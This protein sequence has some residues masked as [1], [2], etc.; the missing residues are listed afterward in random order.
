MKKMDE[1]ILITRKTFLG[2]CVSVI[3]AA[4]IPS[5]LNREIFSAFESQ[6]YL[7]AV[8]Q[9]SPEAMAKA[10]FLN[11][12]FLST[13]AIKNKTVL[14][15]PN[16]GWNVKPELGA[17]TNP[18]IVSET[19]KYFIERGAARVYV[20]DNSADNWKESYTSSGIEK[21]A[22]SAGAI[23]APAHQ[24]S[25]YQSVNIPSGKKLKKTK[26]HEIALSCDLFINLPVLKTHHSTMMT[27]AM[28]NLMGVIWDRYELHSLDLH[29]CIA[30]LNTVIKPQINIVDAYRVMFK[31]GPR[32]TSRS[33]IV[34]KN[35]L[36]ISNDIVSI[37]SASARTL[38]LD[39]NKIKYL[40]IFG[41]D[42]PGF[43]L[44][45]TE[46]KKVAL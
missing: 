45:K 36:F 19:V 27:C 29:Q 8:K 2:K 5:F 42:K 26:I 28:K 46:I 35:Q 32:G 25:Y 34:L 14:V 17:N 37:D 38:N 41:K 13:M 6:P 20:M 11:F 15:K 18:G 44:Q 16:I 43:D 30:D 24:E 31:S 40:A 4:S 9:G 12:K 1:S 10:A 3:L 23:M 39:P 21:A 7:T 22:K 33:D